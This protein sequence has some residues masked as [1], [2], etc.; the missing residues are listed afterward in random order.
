MK[1]YVKNVFLEYQTGNVG[2]DDIEYTGEV[3]GD[4]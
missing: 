4:E 2:I 3:I 1:R